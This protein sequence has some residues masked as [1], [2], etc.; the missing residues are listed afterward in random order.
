VNEKN[1]PGSDRVSAA[2]RRSGRRVAW[3]VAAMLWATAA[4]AEQPGDPLPASEDNAA[5]R[6]CGPAHSAA[7]SQVIRVL[8]AGPRRDDGSLAFVSGL[9]VYLPPDY[10]SGLRRYPVIYWLHGGGGGQSVFATDQLD[11][12]YAQDPDHAV[13]MVGPDASG[14]ATWFDRFDN[15]N[16]NP[17]TVAASP[18]GQGPGYRRTLTETYVLRWVIP[19][20]DQHFRTIP[21]RQGRAT[22]GISNGG[23]GAALLPAKAPDLFATASVMSGN[24]AWQSFSG[25]SEMFLDPASGQFSPAYRAGN[26]PVN[27]AGNLDGVN[28]IFDI[29]A[30]CPTPGETAPA[31]TD[32][33]WGF[34]QLFVR[35]NRDLQTAL[36][37]AGHQG[38]ND[39]RETYGGH[40]IKYWSQWFADRHLPFLLAH[41]AKPE[42]AEA[43][44]PA[45]TVPKQFRYR[46]IANSFSV[47]GY[48]FAVQRANRE[49]L[50]V[51]I[52]GDTVM[53]GGSGK[54]SVTTP[55]LY[56]AGQPYRV[57]DQPADTT[58]TSAAPLVADGDGRL[59]LEIDLGSGAPVEHDGYGDTGFQ[60]APA[61]ATVDAS[62]ATVKTL[63]IAGPRKS[64]SAVTT[65]PPAAG[66]TAVA[67]SNTRTPSA[68]GA[69]GLMTPLLLVL[70][71]GRRNRHKS[72]KP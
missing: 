40:D 35:G 39:Y 10:D 20:I 22:F 63:L 48:Q 45:A 27:L 26:L 16:I 56:V 53:L 11:A 44:S 36:A 7:G 2:V 4:W 66:A 23:L 68:A 67:T 13:I 49:F 69:F 42:S 34:E 25:G 72:S 46:S 24:V 47:Y 64:S 19:Y 1:G 70:A 60:H 12:A 58:S 32:V 55:A 52:D 8:S 14:L 65:T 37:A 31:C 71:A 57:T 38:L 51:A 43:P 62:L 50:D 29:G 21:T 18:P 54:V 28:L 61:D 15:F 6:D 59:H 30:E 33:A 41:L 5:G 3:W 17:Q 9:C